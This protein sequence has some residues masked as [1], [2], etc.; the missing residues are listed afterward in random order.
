MQGEGFWRR[1]KQRLGK[2]IIPRLPITRHVF[3]HLR[4]ELNAF[5]V[6]LNNRLN[7]IYIA[8]RKKIERGTNLSVNVGCGPLGKKGWINLDLMNMP[9]LSLRYDC[10]KSL[11]FRENS[12]GRI[13][14]EH[15]FEHL[16]RPGQVPLFLESCFK[17]L[18]K[19]AVL[20]IVVPDSRRFLLA[21]QTGK[22]EDWAALGWDL[23][24][25]PN[26][27]HTEMDIINDV[28]RQCEEH[29]YAYDFETLEVVLGEAGFDKIIKS[30]FGMSTDPEL[31]DDLPNH[32]PHSLY[33]EAIK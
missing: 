18:R 21:Y 8:R 6:R 25:L 19:G 16:D 23:D 20:R 4:R 14:C 27:F 24:N 17:A 28:F 33:V 1:I 13:R 12:V 9:N 30:E 7:P 2:I 15:F 29:L 3:N 26:G 31:R 10:R 5:W 22:K 32:K 11:P